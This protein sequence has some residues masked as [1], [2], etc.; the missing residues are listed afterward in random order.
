[1][2]ATITHNTGLVV[3]LNQGGVTH[4]AG[5]VAMDNTVFWHKFRPC[6][7]TSSEITIYS[8]FSA[9]VAKTEN[10]ATCNARCPVATIH[11]GTIIGNKYAKYQLRKEIFS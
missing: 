10:V 9:L 5:P 7:A 3:L 2:V 1:M 4:D 6:G 8:I 11:A